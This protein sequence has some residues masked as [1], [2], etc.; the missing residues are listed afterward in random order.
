MAPNLTP[1]SKDALKTEEYFINMG[2]QHPSTH[3]VL[4]LVMKLDGE[5]VLQVVP[6]LGY[7]HRSIEQHVRVGLLPPIGPF[8]RPHG[9]PLGHD[10]QLG[11]RPVRREEP[12][13]HGARARRIHP[14]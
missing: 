4:R 6:H 7:I 12:V 1:Q 10:D 14:R 9:L 5:T 8:H 11:L 13:H 3:G 2:P